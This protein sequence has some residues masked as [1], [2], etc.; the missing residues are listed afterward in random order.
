MAY[1]PY[2][3]KAVIGYDNVFTSAAVAASSETDEG[4]AENAVDGLT[5]DW[6]QGEGDPDTLTVNS[7]SASCDY[8]AIAAHDLGTQSATITLQGSADGAAWVTVA[9][10]YSPTDDTP[11]LWRF[12]QATYAYWRISVAGGPCR[13]GVVNAGVAMVLPEGVYAGHAPA[14]LNR[15]PKLLNNDSEGGQL[16]GRSIIRS[17]ATSEIV[18]ERVSTTWVRDTWQPFARF[19]ET[20]PFFYA[21]RHADF[22]EEVLYAWSD[23]EANVQQGPNQFMKV[24]LDIKG[25]VE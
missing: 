14:S 18:Q 1:V 23:G 22:P 9:G 4:P 2:T 10:P 7:G 11:W 24:S 19:A 17:G 25:Q 3:S 8:L 6:W 15:K 13:I 12:T 5:Y 16:L 20:R 21:W